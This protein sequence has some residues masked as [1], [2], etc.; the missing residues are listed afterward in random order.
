MVG[1]IVGVM[2]GVTVRVGV[3]VGVTVGDQT[4]LLPNFMHLKVLPLI[5]FFAFIC[6]QGEPFLITAES[7]IGDEKSSNVAI[8]VPEKIRFMEKK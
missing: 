7:A 8:K 2:V 5:T 1:V 6:L 4:F 3:T